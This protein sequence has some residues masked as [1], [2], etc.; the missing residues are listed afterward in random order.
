MVE[1]DEYPLLPDVSA[2]RY[3]P[4]GRPIEVTDTGEVRSSFELS[5]ERVRPAVIR[6]SQMGGGAFRRGS[7]GR[8]VVAA[9]IE[10]AAQLAV[11]SAD[12]DDRFAGRGVAGDVLARPPKLVNPTRYLPRTREHRPALEVQHARIRVP[13][14]R[15]RR[16]FCQRG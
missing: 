9:D 2:D 7:H 4:V 10:E 16:R 1:P 12:Q 15:N 5:F 14:R 3:Q 13:L 6:A 11:V 8:G